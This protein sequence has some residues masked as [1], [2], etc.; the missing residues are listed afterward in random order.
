M[1][2]IIVIIPLFI[3]FIACVTNKSQDFQLVALSPATYEFKTKENKNRI[4]YFYSEGNFSYNNTDYEILKKKIEEKI[5]GVNTPKYHLYSIYIYKK[6]NILN[7]QY[8]GG[9]EGLDGHNQDLIAYIRYEKGNKDIFYI[10]KKGNVVYDILSD[11][12]EN[13][14]FDQ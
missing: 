4:D 10:L 14:E 13:F 1:K 3:L 8:K 11:K 5:V 2:K 9:K 7:N 12:E 6:T